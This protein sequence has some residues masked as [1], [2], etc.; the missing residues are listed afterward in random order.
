MIEQNVMVIDTEKDVV[1]QVNGLAVYD[2]GYYSFGKPSRITCTVSLGDSGII[3]IEKEADLSGSSHSKG[4]MIL[5]GFLRER[6]GQKFP[7]S[8]TASIC[9]EQSYGGVDGD[10]ASS[11]E[12]YCLLSGLS[13]KPI[14]Q[15]FAVTGSV[16]QKGEVQAI[17]GVIEKIE[18]FFQVCKAFGLNG[19]QGVLIPQA[20]VEELM[21]TDEVVTAVEKGLFHIFPIAHVDQG[22]EVLTG[23]PAGTADEKGDFPI[24][25]INGLV[26]KKLKKMYYIIHDKKRKKKEKVK[27]KEPQEKKKGRGKKK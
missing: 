22:I 18:G 17:G 23:V 10:S 5:S 20:N 16:N 9:F 6:F 4:I 15:H 11:T 26:M 12:L 25:S 21:L 1:G 27:V 7:I 24:D 14:K 8:L 3:N 13:G 2:L 19:K